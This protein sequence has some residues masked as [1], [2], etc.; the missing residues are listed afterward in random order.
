M[1]ISRRTNPDLQL[2]RL[3]RKHLALKAQV[4]AY[5]SRLS[6]T[7]VEQMDLLRLKKQKLITKDE[8]HQL[9]SV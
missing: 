5:Q 6:L 2:A 8:I 9:N 7:S 4:D 1:A 3:E